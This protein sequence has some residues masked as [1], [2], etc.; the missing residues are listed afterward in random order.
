MKY[1]SPKRIK[2]YNTAKKNAINLVD[3][4]EKDSFKNKWVFVYV[5]CQHKNV[6][7]LKGHGES[8]FDVVDVDLGEYMNVVGKY[9]MI[10]LSKT[11]GKLQVEEILDGIE[12]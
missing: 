4:I 1:S 10:K 2:T 11:E 8:N 12:D 7:R 3:L 9:V 5:E 6:Y